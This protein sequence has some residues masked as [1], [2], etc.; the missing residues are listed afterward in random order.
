MKKPSETISSSKLFISL[1][2]EDIGKI[3]TPAFIQNTSL[4]LSNGSLANIKDVK[5]LSTTSNDI[6]KSTF[7]FGQ[8]LEDR[9][10]FNSFSNINNDLKT[11]GLKSDHLISFSDVTK[12]DETINSGNSKTESSLLSVIKNGESSNIE[13]VFK[14]KYEVI[15]GEEGYF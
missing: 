4:N 10:G 5:N 3:K 9:V 13:N 6:S 1:N 11:D 7:L 12:C 14:R 15:T 8:K 2:K